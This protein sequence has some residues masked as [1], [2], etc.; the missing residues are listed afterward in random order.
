MIA[1]DKFDSADVLAVDFETSVGDETVGA[2]ELFS[3]AGKVKGKTISGAY[4]ATEWESFWSKNNTKKIIFHNAKFDLAVMRNSGINVHEVDF[5]D[6]LI[7]AHLIDELRRKGLKD[8]RQSELSLPERPGWKHIDRSNEKEYK[9]Y[10]KQDAEDTFC[11]YELFKPEIESQGLGSVYA[12]EKAVVFPTMEMEMHGVKLDLELL[13]DQR[14][15]VAKYVEESQ[16]EIFDTIGYEIN[17]AS[18]KQLQELLFEVLEYPPRP[19]W[20]TKTGYSTNANVLEFISLDR[21]YP[22][23]RAVAE[24]LIKHRMFSKIQ[25]AFINGLADRVDMT[26]RYVY[27]RFNALGTVSG[28]F[29]GSDPN[30]QQIPR[31]PFEEGKLNTHIRS[32][33]VC[34]DDEYIIT[35][36]YCVA[37]DTK[38][39]M[40]D[41]T[42]KSAEDVAV[43]D[44]VIGFP[45]NLGHGGMS[46]A[47]VERVTS[48]LQPCVKIVTD[49]GEVVSSLEHR[50]PVRRTKASEGKGKRKGRKGQHP[51]KRFWTK[52]SDI[53]VGDTLSFFATPWIVDQSREAGYLAG[54]FD[55]EGNVHDIS[56]GFAQNEGITINTVLEILKDKGYDTPMQGVGKAGC[57]KF[58]IRGN[59]EGLRFIG[60][61]RPPRLLQKS[62]KMWE[63]RRTWGNNSEPATVLSVERVGV[64]KVIGLQTSTKTFIANGFLSHNSQ[65]EL[66]VMAE[67]SND[68]NLVK[69]YM[70]NMD[71][72]QMTADSLGLSRQD[73]K[74]LNFGIGYGLSAGGFSR[75][76]G[77]SFKK[78]QQYVN[79]FWH[80]YPGLRVFFDHVIKQAQNLGYI[81]TM[82]GR[83]RRINF[84]D[85]GPERQA[86]NSIIQG[87]A[88]DVMKLALVKAYQWLDHS[89]CAFI[90]TVHDE[91]SLVADR[92]YTEEAREILQYCM[93]RCV[94]SKVPF[95]ANI[96]VGRRWSENK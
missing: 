10:A 37:P 52:S 51:Y 81:R 7:M 68:K 50:W 25:S 56:V 91:V 76:T 9:E 93:E 80:T 43:G 28:R 90:M 3:V 4:N 41:L 87:S 1:L 63:G 24:Q 23:A 85:Y 66:R 11:L 69:C 65:I 62:R 54:F 77:M 75:L 49:K 32:L 30:L 16:A 61:V 13:D 2:M 48:L 18:P 45:E 74:S 53:E 84:Q 71:I 94:N 35:A 79:G 70:H 96:S 39:L 22:R 64:R 20:E 92:N 5:E 40:D 46:S 38:V 58:Y 82:S 67:L 21:G 88:A 6:T 72:H 36:D 17:L 14:E 60:S 44:Y 19:E 83:K 29:S 73:S 59:K 8:L 95:L 31:T 34:E 26:T 12:L 86:C 33:F 15:L 78:A 27:P 47:I 55:G 42:W 89:R 57:Q